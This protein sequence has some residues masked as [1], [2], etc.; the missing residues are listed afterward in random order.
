MLMI[1]DRVLYKGRRSIQPSEKTI[2]EKE[3]KE[4]KESNVK[5]KKKKFGRRKFIWKKKKQKETDFN[6]EE[7]DKEF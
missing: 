4:E 3:E 6:I 2:E 7:I 1:I 5:K